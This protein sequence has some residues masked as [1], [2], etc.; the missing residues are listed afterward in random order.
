MDTRVHEG[1]KTHLREITFTELVSATCAEFP[2]I[3]F[4]LLRVHR[5]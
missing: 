4:V 1:D 3:S 5:G 2:R